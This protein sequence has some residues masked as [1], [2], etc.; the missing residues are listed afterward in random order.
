MNMAI[1]SLQAWCLIQCLTCI[2]CSEDIQGKEKEKREKKE[3]RRDSLG[4][5]YLLEL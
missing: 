1:L 4:K 2:T 3:K 5:D